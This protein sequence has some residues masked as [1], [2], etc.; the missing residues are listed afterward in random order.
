MLLQI[1][2]IIISMIAKLL[3]LRTPQ[4]IKKHWHATLK[5]R[6][7]EATQLTNQVHNNNTTNTNTNYNNDN[8]NGIVLHDMSHHYNN[9]NNNNNNNNG[10]INTHYPLS[11]AASLSLSL[12]QSLSGVSKGVGGSVLPF[13]TTHTGPGHHP[14]FMVQAAL[15]QMGKSNNNLNTNDNDNNINNDNDNDNTN[16]HYGSHYYH[17]SSLS[18]LPTTTAPTTTTTTNLPKAMTT[19][20]LHQNDHN[21]TEVECLGAYIQAVLYAQSGL[22]NLNSFDY[23]LTQPMMID[24]TAFVQEINQK[25]YQRNLRG[26]NDNDNDMN[27]NNNNLSVMMDHNMNMN[28][29]NRM[30]TTDT[31]TNIH[32]SG[33]T[34]TNNNN[35]IHHD[36]NNENDTVPLH[37]TRPSLS[38]CSELVFVQ[39]LFLHFSQGLSNNVGVDAHGE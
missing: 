1:I 38:D 28:H 15:S 27:N 19:T 33:T 29:H 9:N 39:D 31:T 20:E 25:Q 18:Y 35:N 4:A 17:N 14:M 30:N 2:M 21:D 5:F 6:L 22:L 8:G 37:Y 12:T 10:T 13:P 26:D 7:D 11:Q 32:I 16:H 23:S 3:P 36:T 24:P 34:T